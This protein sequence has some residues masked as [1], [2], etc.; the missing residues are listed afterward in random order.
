MKKFNE[1][2]S[3]FD[4]VQIEKDILDVWQ[5]ENIFNNLENSKKGSNEWVYYDGPITANGRP[6]YGHAITWTMKDVMPRFWTM[7]GYYVN[8]NMGWDC[9][10]ILVEYE[11]EKQLE[12]KEKGDIEKYGI[13]NFNDK[14]RDSVLSFRS[15]MIQYETRLGRWLDKKH[16][17]TMDSDYIE[18]I[19]W[20]LKTLYEKGLLY[21]GHKVVAYSTRAGMT[22]SSH[23]VADGGYKEVTDPA[24]T[25]KFKLSEE[26]KYI[27]AWT[28]TPWTIPGNLMLA[29]GKK[30]EYVEVECEGE[31]LILAK[32]ALERVLGDKY[33]KV[34]K[35]VKAEELEGKSYDCVFPYYSNKRNE[36]A[37]KIIY[38]N[39]VNTTDG[40]GVVH[41]APYGEEDFNILTGMGLAL[42]DYLDEEG[43]FTADIPTYKGLF[44]KKANKQIIDDLTK[45]NNL[46][47][48]K[49][50]LHSMP[51]CYR[52]K[53]PLIYKPV[54]SW[55]LAVNKIK[56]QL[57]EEAKKV[58]IVPSD[59]GKRFVAWVEGAR[60][61]S[62]SRQRYWGTPMPLWVN[63]KTGDFKF[64]GSFKELGELSGK[65]LD[66]NFDPHRPYVDDITWEADGGTYRRVKDVIDVWFDSGSMPYAQHHYPFENTDVFEKRFPAEYISESE[67]QIRLWFYTMFLLGNALFGKTPFKNVV[68]TGMLGDETGKKMSKS[69]G[70]YPPV[71]EVFEKYGSDMLRYFLLSSPIARGL[72]TSF[73]Y[74]FLLETKKEFFSVFW[75]S[76]RYFVTYANLYDFKV[77][78]ELAVKSENILDKWILQRLDEVK[79]S[80]RTNMEKYE[81][82]YALREL[83]PFVNDL[84]TWYIR[85]SRDRLSSGDG[86]SLNVLYKVLL[87]LTKLMAPF[88]PLL[89]DTVYRN[90]ALSVNED[91][92]RSV[93]MDNFPNASGKAIDIEL[94]STMNLVR[95]IASVGNALRKV[96][97][98]AVKQPLSIMYVSGSKELNDEF[99]ALLKDELNVKEISFVDSLDN[100][101]K[102]SQYIVGKDHD[103][104][105]AFDITVTG[106]LEVEGY[107]RE[108]IREI[109]KIRKANNVDWSASI[110]LQ[111]EDKPEYERAIGMFKKEIME[112]GLVSELVKGD[113]FRI[114]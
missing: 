114:L 90:L 45:M 53:E 102:D 31:T 21:R 16:Y 38:A 74:D 76:Y 10:G 41:L 89:S 88:M 4:L 42:F 86:Q 75:N 77:D 99:I 30:I 47:D 62:L 56:P 108:M 55:Y 37:F 26:D 82:M 34:V 33:F 64:I 28:T 11:V 39:H 68:V 101:E 20:A 109:Q 78:E 113:M 1:V 8:R 103:M 57:I 35:D 67:D 17:S 24:V 2:S 29:I 65:E 97:N 98:L 92:F 66:P 27:L 19:W 63:D 100:K 18:S 49:E 80:M 85:R 54:E 51:M 71:E 110:K 111:Y 22:L 14:C 52:T 12:F 84:S 93:H 70:N 46:F 73:S 6:H 72:P 3:N 50:H 40:T 105:V 59:M 69:K 96:N 61:W 43:H 87:D 44:Y 107:A 5:K 79:E 94:L 83:A 58:N 13:S 36:G 60:D 48:Y 7:N 25:V 91:A 106:E 23:E 104:K 32:D 112:K 9:Q 81:I 15:A 95:D